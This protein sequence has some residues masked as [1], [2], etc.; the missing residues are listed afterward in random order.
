MLLVEHL[1]SVLVGLLVF[2][3]CFNLDA[4]YDAVSL[5]VVRVVSFSLS[6]ISPAFAVTRYSPTVWW[7]DLVPPHDGRLDSRSLA[8]GRCG[9]WIIR[10]V[11]GWMPITLIPLLWSPAT[12]IAL[13]CWYFDTDEVETFEEFTRRCPPDRASSQRLHARLVV[14]HLLPRV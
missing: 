14:R 2:L 1:P 10:A 4:F 6:F 3:L 9:V 12:M 5:P 13:I 8:V 7:W 11:S